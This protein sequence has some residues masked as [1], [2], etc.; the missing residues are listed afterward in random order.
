[1]YNQVFSTI[2]AL[3]TE[4]NENAGILQKKTI[5][6]SNADRFDEF[7]TDKQLKK[8][9]E[10]LFRDGHHSRAV[11]EAFKFIDNLVKR[12]AKPPDIGLTGSKLMTTVFNV[13]TPLLKIN[14]GE[15]ISERDEQNGYMQIL[16]GCMTGI[17]NPRAHECDWEDSE[18]RALQLLIF[19]NHLVER[20]RLSEK[21][22]ITK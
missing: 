19:S 15:S 4:I 3:K 7:I 12:T 6:L 14:A 2:K 13:N 16:S 5:G 9:V 22:T 10:K 18:T 20:I 17:R 8:T 1:M 11:E 21:H